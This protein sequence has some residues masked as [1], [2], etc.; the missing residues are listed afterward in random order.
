MAYRRFASSLR[1]G[2]TNWVRT[3]TT[4]FRPFAESRIMACHV[5]ESNVPM[6]LYLAAVA[7]LFSSAVCAADPS[8]ATEAEIAHLFTYLVT[9]DCEFYRNGSWYPTPEASAHIKRKYEYLRR[10]GL[11]STA[12]SFIERAASASSM[13]GKPYLVKCAEREPVES[14]SWLGEELERYRRQRGSGRG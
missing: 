6:R 2:R 3:D 14:A 13:S 8:A 1:P 4:G 5:L 12:E 10:R 7:L 11:V 9:S